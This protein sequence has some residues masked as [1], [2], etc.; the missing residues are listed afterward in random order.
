MSIVTIR[1][2]L[3][4]GC[5][6]GHQTRYWCPRMSPYIFGERNKLHIINLEQTQPMLKD[7]VNFLGSVAA[8]NGKV[9][10]V[11][12]KRQASKLIK[13]EAERC[14][15]PYVN[16]RWLGGMLTNY[17]TVKKSVSRLKE[18]EGMIESGE[19]NKLRK[20]EALQFD[21]ER[22]KLDKSL[23]GIKNMGGLPSA[24]FVIDREHEYIAVN[25]ANKLGI[26][27]VA[28]VDSNCSPN[29]IDYVIPGNDDAIRAIRL[30][31]A[32]IADAVNDAKQ[33]SLADQI[34][35]LSESTDEFV[36]I[37]EEGEVMS[38]ASAGASDEGA[39]PAA[40]VTN[41]TSD[42]EADSQTGEKKVD[43][44][45]D[46]APDASETPAKK[47]AKKKVV[48][49]AA[50]K[51]EASPAG[52][53]DNLTDING[54]GPVIEGKLKAMGITTLRQIAEFDQAKSDEVN[55]QLSFKGRIEREE[56]VKQAKALSE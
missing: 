4:A 2:L 26:P 32:K 3:E 7:A 29:G 30:Y 31:L 16:H 37:T 8:Q 54:I 39:V 47:V 42:T 56:W 43:V 25:E 49:K 40:K 51:A 13:Q 27:V 50:P 17:K 10:F 53:G 45:A 55:E 38:D 9:L 15:M 35:T 33:A 46:K 22:A 41:S 52:E 12:T 48:K 14:G 18:M 34:A 19:I 1:E 28:V 6:F 11:G 23:A 24:L 20:K 5:H 44:D 36:E 21:R